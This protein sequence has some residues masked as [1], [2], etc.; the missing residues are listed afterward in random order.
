MVHARYGICFAVAEEDLGCCPVNMRRRESYAIARG[1]KKY[2]PGQRGSAF[3]TQTIAESI[4]DIIRREMHIIFRQ[5]FGSSLLAGLL[6]VCFSF[7]VCAGTSAAQKTKPKRKPLSST[8]SVRS[9]TPARAVKAP[10]EPDVQLEQLPPDPAVD[11]ADISIT[12]HI[13]ARS[14]KFETV[15]NPTVEF[16]G[17]PARDTVWEAQRENLP[18]PVEPGVTY[19][20]IGIRLKIT[21][22]FRDID[23][24]V[25]EAL[26]EVPIT[27]DTTTNQA[28]S[29]SKPAN[30]SKAQS[31]NSKRVSTPPPSRERP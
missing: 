28:P 9:K 5:S 15:P 16:P 11:N 14:L 3:Q 4:A 8:Q 1:L 6:V 20:N 19:R 21:S 24:I 27:E 12:A 22:V 18:T 25:A 29:A 31:A 2:S 23:R 30:E 10:R 26:G 13:R 7:V 17:Q